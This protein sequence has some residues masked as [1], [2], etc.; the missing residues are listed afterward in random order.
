MVVSGSGT[1]VP[2]VLKTFL[3][4]L[5]SHHPVLRRSAGRAGYGFLLAPVVWLWEVHAELS[6]NLVLHPDAPQELLGFL[7]R[8]RL[9]FH[10][11]YPH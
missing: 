8:L 4:L 11:I 3:L 10:Q 1:G 6:R 7:I 5:K 9:Y 2:A